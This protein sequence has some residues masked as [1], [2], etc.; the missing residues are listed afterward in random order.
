MVKLWA[1]FE[2][3]FELRATEGGHGVPR[4]ES[5]PVQS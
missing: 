2:L 1:Y 3:R 5:V 4:I